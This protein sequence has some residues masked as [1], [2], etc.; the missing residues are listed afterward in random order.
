MHTLHKMIHEHSDRQ[1]RN[2]VEWRSATHI[3]TNGRLTPSVHS[4]QWTVRMDACAIKACTMRARESYDARAQLQVCWNLSH[5]YISLTHSLPEIYR[6]IK[7][8]LLAWAQ[9]KY[10]LILSRLARPLDF[11]SPKLSGRA[12]WEHVCRGALTGDRLLC[13][14]HWSMRSPIY[15]LLCSLPTLNHN[16]FGVEKR[17]SCKAI[18]HIGL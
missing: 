13:E 1:T 16:A 3:Q 14:K 12:D 7:V 15:L 8:W 11:G 17:G 9:L 2:Y 5:N 18:H 6:Q 4:F 10:H